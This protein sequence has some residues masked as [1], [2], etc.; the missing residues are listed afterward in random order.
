M[1]TRTWWSALGAV[2]VLAAL[3][4]FTGIGFGLDL[5]D[6]ERTQLWSL[7]DERGMVEAVQAEILQ[8]SL[9]PGKFLYRGPAGLVLFGVPDA[10]LVALAPGTWA[11]RMQ[12]LAANPSFLHL[13]HRC[14]AALAGVAGVLVLARMLRR[15]LGDASGL[16]G[17][18]VYAVA[19][20]PV[21]H[22]HFGTVDTLWALSMLLALDRMLAWIRAPSSGNAF[23]SGLWAGVSAAVKYFSVLL[24][25]HLL[26]AW[27]LARRARPE[28]D[29]GPGR[30][31]RPGPTG[32]Q[33]DAITTAGARCRQSRNRSMVR[34]LI[35]RTL[36]SVRPSRVEMSDVL[37]ST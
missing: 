27:F 18:L 9:H 7:I 15:E 3:L 12:A 10:V 29:A 32:R 25:A 22:A 16:A 30:A 11:E 35:T 20:L 13:V 24:G 26:L 5:D 19:Y 8:G 31:G 6:P 21:S 36:A 33:L 28:R 37:A 2:L 4:R 23:A 34:C 1:S 14:I 17:G